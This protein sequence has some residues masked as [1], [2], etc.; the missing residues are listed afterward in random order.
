MQRTM[1]R[2]NLFDFKWAAFDA[3]FFV[4][5]VCLVLGLVGEGKGGSRI[6][7]ELCGI[8]G[9]EVI[10]RLVLSPGGDFGPPG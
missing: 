8:L 2:L 9:D 7:T 4:C 10:R 1:T 3:A 6:F 5:V